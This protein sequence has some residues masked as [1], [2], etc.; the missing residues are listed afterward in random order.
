M[1]ALPM[2]EPPHA[3]EALGLRKTYPGGS[4]ALRGVDFSLRSGE[5][6]VLLGPNGAGKTTLVKII[7]GLLLPDT[8]ELKLFGARPVPAMR[9]RL[10]FL[11]EEAD[12]LYGYL[13]G[14]E[15]LLFYGRVAGVR[16]SV[17]HRRASALLT[18]FELEAA[19]GQPAQNLSR[20]QK[21][22]LALASVL[23]QEAEV[24]VL[25]EPTL[26]L[27]LPS[28]HDLVERIKELS[29]VLVTT[30][31]PVL[32][33][34]VAERFVVMK[35]GEVREVLTRSDLSAAGVH[36]PEELRSWLLE[37]YR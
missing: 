14:W 29:T 13:T 20:G 12:N 11:F 24:Y 32:A 7:A 37:V 28:Q 15:N 35:E 2:K 1:A 34:E 27:D 36:D 4:E 18:E 21:Q 16:E 10:G 9:R 22:R 17:L 30:H 6:V 3:V 25:D 26:G 8:G 19:K 23:I 33:W 31:D 5:R